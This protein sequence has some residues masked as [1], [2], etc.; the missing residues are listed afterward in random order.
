MCFDTARPGQYAGLNRYSMEI[1]LSALLFL[2]SYD[3][4]GNIAL[5]PGV[6]TDSPFVV[7]LLNGAY[8]PVNCVYT[9]M[10]GNFN[11][12][13]VLPGIYNIRVRHD[14]FDDAIQRVEVP[15][16]GE[17][18]N[19]PVHRGHPH[20]V[21]DQSPHLGDDYHVNVRQL[22]TPPE[23]IRHYQKA[24]TELKEGNTDRGIWHLQRAIGIS[25]GFLEAVY[26]LSELYYASQRYAD[27]EQLLAQTL[28]AV[29]TEEHLRLVLA[30]VFVRE[31]KFK[32]ALSEV[33]AYLQSDAKDADREML[34]KFRA[35]LVRHM[36]PGP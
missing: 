17:V 5:D 26:E 31:R 13:D 4:Q 20:N 30:R 11:F 34:E 27:A 18:P 21:A 22:A 2:A 1:L 3:I 6:V 14:G 23:A 24:L 28:A 35:K 10:N 16:S 32:E 29:P 15:S 25:P 9:T 19:I 8:A 7:E 12:Q 33:D 36:T